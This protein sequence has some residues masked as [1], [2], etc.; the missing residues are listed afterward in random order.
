MAGI[1]VCKDNYWHPS[2]RDI[3]IAKRRSAQLQ[4]NY[5][6][7]LAHALYDDM[8]SGEGD[9]GSF[10]LDGGKIEV[11]TSKAQ[12][13]FSVGG[14]HDGLVLEDGE[15]LNVDSVRIAVE[16]L[17]DVIVQLQNSAPD[18]PV[19]VGWQ[20]ENELWYFDV[21]NVITG[22]NNALATSQA[23]REP[24]I[25]DME[26]GETICLKDIPYV[27]ATGH[28]TYASFMRERMKRKLSS[29][30]DDIFD[31]YSDVFEALADGRKQL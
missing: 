25:F 1:W 26:H 23:R 4:R 19:C 31:E 22:R 5:A 20:R 3:Q 12:D 14:T 29:D 15:V 27:T 8:M 6:D 16:L 21:C 17:H 13:L 30:M 10:Y 11:G 18:D 7:T 24:S 2:S 9:R 28:T